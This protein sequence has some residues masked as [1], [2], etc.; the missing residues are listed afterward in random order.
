MDLRYIKKFANILNIYE[1]IPIEN[2]EALLINVVEAMP[3]R[4]KIEGYN[5]V[6]TKKD[7]AVY[8]EAVKVVREKLEEMV[9][10]IEKRK[11]NRKYS[12]DSKDFG[13]INRRIYVEARG[14]QDKYKNVKVDYIKTMIENLL[15]GRAVKYLDD[16]VKDVN[17]YLN[18]KKVRD[19][20]RF[21]FK[22]Q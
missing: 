18:D 13:L 7:S 5:Y 15:E 20:N 1:E 11:G 2:I 14:L 22:K 16:V 4:Q 19:A 12:K 8:V 9:K 17:I 3:P 6:V 21:N 10:T